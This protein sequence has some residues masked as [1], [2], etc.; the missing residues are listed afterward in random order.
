M[1]L[2]EKYLIE[3][4]LKAEARKAL[5]RLESFKG[6]I[7]KIKKRINSMKNPT[8]VAIFALALENENY[9]DMVDLCA[10]RYYEL[11]SGSLTDSDIWNK[12]G[13]IYEI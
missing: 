7:P 10:E 3:A 5:I 6:S 12:Y 4:S 11:T 2:Y 13:N 1:K 8:K 9:H